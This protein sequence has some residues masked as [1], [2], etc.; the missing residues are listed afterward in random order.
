MFKQKLNRY[1]VRN[2]EILTDN[3]LS[4]LLNNNWSRTPAPIMK[5]VRCGGRI[6]TYNLRYFG[7][8]PLSVLC[9]KCQDTNECPKPYNNG[10]KEVVTV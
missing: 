9:Y 10:R 2:K 5:C 3:V 4:E 1:Q 7:Y 6:S 8:D